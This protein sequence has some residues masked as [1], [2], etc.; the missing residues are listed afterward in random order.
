ME[1]RKGALL[2]TAGAPDAAQLEKINRLTR[3][4]LQAEEVYVF[5]VRLCDDQPDRDFECFDRAALETL[6][7]LFLGRTGIVDHQWSAENQLA[8]I[9]DTAVLC[10]G[11]A[12]YLKAWAYMLRGTAS[13][14]LIRQI[15]GG[16][17]KEVSVGCAVA[18]TTCSICGAPYGTCEHRKGME[19]GGEICVA[20]LSDPTDAYEF[21]FVAVPAQREAGVIKS[22]KGGETMNLQELVQKSAGE[23][24]RGEFQTL[25]KQAALGRAYTEEQ[26]RE[27]VRL[28]L[29]LDIGLNEKQLQKLASRLEMDEL[30]EIRAA[31][32]EKAAE[33]FPPQPQ[34][35]SCTVPTSGCEGDYLI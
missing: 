30:G 15:E 17:R 18:K 26:R 19:Y 14:E 1:I 21:S 20:V 10:E 24:A 3:S 25:C 23:Q 28:G 6:A 8:R 34:L 12:H 16:I 35:Q 33:L 9:F 27:I 4:P 5:S 7:A 11:G 22:W 29:V 32:E 2:G 31:L 13:D